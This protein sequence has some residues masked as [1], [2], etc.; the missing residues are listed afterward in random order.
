MG[1][2]PPLHACQESTATIHSD[3]G[4]W[5]ILENRPS[6]LAAHSIRMTTRAAPLSRRSRDPHNHADAIA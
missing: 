4:V 5:A 6:D 1:S 2:G 3:L